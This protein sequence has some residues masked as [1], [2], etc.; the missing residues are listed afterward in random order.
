MSSLTPPSFAS[1]QPP[2]LSLQ[3]PSLQPSTEITSEKTVVPQNTGPAAAVTIAPEMQKKF[4]ERLLMTF[5]SYFVEKDATFKLSD[6]GNLTVDQLCQIVMVEL[7][8]DLHR[9]KPTQKRECSSYN[10]YD[11]L[12]TFKNLLVSEVGKMK[13]NFAK[14][15]NR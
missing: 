4:F 6:L 1:L 11:Y 12:I 13:I 10:Q 2:S 7:F 8:T 3:P 9:L 14:F 5:Q 15:L